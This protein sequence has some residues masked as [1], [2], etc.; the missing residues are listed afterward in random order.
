MPPSAGLGRSVRDLVG[1]LESSK[2]LGPNLV[3][4]RVVPAR[5]AEL[6]DWP[7]GISPEILAVLAR[8]GL[9]RP[10]SH[11]AE[12]IRLALAGKDVVVVTPTASGKTLCYNVPVLTAL[13]TDSGARALYLFP[14]K[15]LAQ[16]QL[17]ELR[18]WWPAG[19]GPLRPFTYD[20]DTPGDARRAVRDR[21]NLV[22]S[23][24]DMLHTGILPHHPRWAPFFQGL[25]YVVVDEVHTYR[26]V[27]GSHVAGVMRRL[28]RVAAFHGSRPVF[29]AASAT[30]ANAGEL[31]ER[32]FGRPFT[33]VDRDG[34]PRSPKTFFVYNPPVVDRQLG[35]RANS[36]KQAELLARRFLDQGR[37]T[38]VFATSR[39]NVEVLTRY[40]QEAYPAKPGQPDRVRGYR[41][42]Y[43]PSVRR[44]IENG[45]RSGETLG[46]VSTNALELGIDI[47]TL[48][49][50]ILA[51]Y[52]GTIASTLQQAGRAGRRSE[53]SIAILV[54]RSNPLDQYLAENPDFL[55]DRSPE[56]ALVNPENLMVLVAHLQCAAFEIPFE[57]GE[58]FGGQDVAEILAFLE[59]RGTLHKVGGRFHWMKDA[60]PAQEVNLRTS[61]AGN[62]VVV[63]AQGETRVLGEVDHFAA[64]VTLYEGAIHLVEGDA[65]QVERLDWEGKKAFVRRTDCDYYTDAISYTH[66]KVLDSMERRSSGPVVLEEGEV[67]ITERA[68]GFKKIRHH[69]MEN[70]GY[71]EIRLPENQMATM[72][73]WFTIPQEL[74]DKIVVPGEG[75][76]SSAP[77]T[78]F[79]AVDGLLGILYAMHHAAAF[80]SMCDPRDLGR[81]IGDR[82]SEWFVHADGHRRGIYAGTFPPGASGAAMRDLRDPAL[83]PRFEPTLFLF[84]RVA[85]G[86]GLAPDLFRRYEE[87]LDRTA[88]TVSACPCARGCPSCVG[89][90]ARG[91]IGSKPAARAILVALRAGR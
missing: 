31:A 72:A 39:L 1:D 70:V 84:D 43:L 37:Q 69:T 40:L 90:M 23:N 11:Q 52:P 76:A 4:R 42:G 5:P 36:L 49:V 82:T 22:L 20:G 80:L 89:P 85:G 19:D 13:A 34:S 59:E 51:G 74:L 63:D 18:R 58:R 78:R 14:T 17:E 56:R 57:E 2:D 25:R 47:G 87:L 3:A 41:G 35:I 30:I 83:L 48:E 86:V 67:E 60:F 91:G 50:A 8:R 16:D 29:L 38:I 54:A 46:V 33:V 45:V 32:L 44:E 65:Y 7:G 15:A 21:A 6:A 55:F 64:H 10:F 61:P 26:G 75:K 79:D 73:F 27:F 71:G 77:L 68:I 24:P 81:A 62:F 66:V 28:A 9:D 88:G 12:A 53:D